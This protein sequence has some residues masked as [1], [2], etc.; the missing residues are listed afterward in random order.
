MAVHG[1]KGFV[2]AV[3]EEEFAAILARSL[4]ACGYE[5]KE[6][7]RLPAG[8]LHAEL[9]PRL[10]AAVGAR[11]V[12]WFRTDAGD[13]G[14]VFDQVLQGWERWDLP[15]VRALSEEAGGFAAVVEAAGTRDQYGAALFWAGRTVELI[16]LDA[17]HP[18][19]RL[20]AP[21]AL[22]PG[23]AEEAV[24]AALEGW[25]AATTGGG[26]GDLRL[27]EAAEA[28][29]LIVARP[30][31]AGDPYALD[32]A[33]EPPFCRA[34]FAL[35]EAAAFEAAFREVSRGEADGW[36]WLARETPDVGA[37]YV[38]L[39]R[40]GR[41]DESFVTALA[42]ACD[43]TV[44]AVELAAQGEPFTWLEME[45]GGPV[46]RGRDLGAAAFLRLWDA[47]AVTLAAAPGTLRRPRGNS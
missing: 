39:E 6:R 5:E 19:V 38:L 10:A 41:L 42:R 21:P 14:V 26:P 27:P 8:R 32:P 28:E 29:V 44:A 12:V 35:V 4:A 2:P 36:R 47:F 16:G 34:A 3:G 40:D 7:L 17:E 20:G 45:P 22:P 23:G 1:V 18:E 13:G 33:A 15:L 9:A 43:A 46:R 30:R 11:A 31:P 25:F 37:P 24:I